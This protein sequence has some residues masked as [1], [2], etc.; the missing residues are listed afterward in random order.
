[1]GTPREVNAEQTAEAAQTLASVSP[2]GCLGACGPAAE[3]AAPE[4]E[5]E[6]V[7]LVLVVG[8]L[9]HLRCETFDF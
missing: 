1:M 4:A 5:R 2:A 9:T 7:Y 6:R 8:H 3:R